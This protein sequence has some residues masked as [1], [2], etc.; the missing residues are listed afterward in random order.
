MTGLAMRYLLHNF[1]FITDTFLAQLMQ[2]Q[3]LAAQQFANFRIC[4]LCLMTQVV[5]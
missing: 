3:L 2:R 5:S 1:M 4:A